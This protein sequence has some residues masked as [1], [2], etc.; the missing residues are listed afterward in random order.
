MEKFGAEARVGPG[1][2]LTRD[3]ILSGKQVRFLALWDAQRGLVGRLTTPNGTIWE[4]PFE[5]ERLPRVEELAASKLGVPAP[6]PP[7]SPFSLGPSGAVTPAMISGQLKPVVGEVWVMSILVESE[8]GGEFRY[9]PV[10]IDGKPFGAART[11]G[12]S[13]FLATFERAGSVGFRL[14]VRVLQATDTHVTWVQLDPKRQ[15]VGHP[16][17]G[18]LGMFV[19][20]FVPEAAAY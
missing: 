3:L 13:D 12:R 6:P 15:P 16:K 4:E 10:D 5:L 2:A 7:P 18:A 1:L 8:S 17:N 9:V 14:P 20:H 19:N 11:L